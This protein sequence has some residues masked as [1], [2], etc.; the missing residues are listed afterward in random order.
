V[1]V[2]GGPGW[3]PAETAG[4]AEVAAGFGQDGIRLAITRQQVQDL[5]PAGLDGK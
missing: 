5:A 3:D 2:G 1:V 4:P